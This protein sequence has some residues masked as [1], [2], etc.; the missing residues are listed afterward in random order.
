MLSVTERPAAAFTFAAVSTP[1][2]STAAAMPAPA[3]AGRTG[4]WAASSTR[5]VRPPMAA[6][7]AAAP[8]MKPAAADNAP[9]TA[10]PKR[11]NAPST[12][13]SP[14]SRGASMMPNAPA[15]TGAGSDS[16][17]PVQ[18]AKGTWRDAPA[19]AATAAGPTTPSVSLSP[20]SASRLRSS[21][22]CSSAR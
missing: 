5:P 11:D 3:S 8:P 19:A 17:S 12:T 1:A 9:L 14:G 13:G 16:R 2:P 4:T 7:L 15:T 10:R 22:A 20:P 6:R 21:D 18:R